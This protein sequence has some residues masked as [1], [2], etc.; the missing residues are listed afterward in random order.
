[1]RIELRLP[2][3]K[4][5]KLLELLQGWQFKKACTR[6]SLESLL[7]HLNHACQVVKPERSFIGRLITI[8]TQAKRTH[9]RMIRI[10]HEARS[11]IR[12]WLLSNCGTGYLY[13]GINKDLIQTIRSGQMLP[14]PGEPVQYGSLTGSKFNGQ[15]HSNQNR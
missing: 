13:Y 12:W 5:S 1:M 6:D 11:D 14:A 9:H 2:H 4:L 10:N 7:G 8:L 3:E 15:Q